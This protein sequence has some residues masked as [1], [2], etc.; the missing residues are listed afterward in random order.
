MGDSFPTASV[1]DFARG[2]YITMVGWWHA[3]LSEIDIYV[4]VLNPSNQGRFL[5]PYLEVI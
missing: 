4:V 1:L 5:D 2:L 3:Q